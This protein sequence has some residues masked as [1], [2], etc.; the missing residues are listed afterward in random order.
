MLRII[1]L[2]SLFVTVAATA[3]L[4]IH[5]FVTPIS[6]PAAAT[7]HSIVS[8][9]LALLLVF[10]TN[11]SYDRWWEGRKLWGSMVNTCRNF[12]RA[13]S[14]HLA[15]D[16]DLLTRV[17]ELISAFPQATTAVLRGQDWAAAGLHE[18]DRKHILALAHRPTAVCQRITYHLKAARDRGLISDLVFLS[19]DA[20]CQTLVDVIGACERI[21]KTPLPFAY[22]VHLRRALV[23]YCATLPLALLSSFGWTTVPIVFGVSYV[24]LGIEEIGVEIEDPFE[25]DDND[26]PLEK[27][28]HSIETNVRAFRP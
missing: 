5:F 7:V 14:V 28:T 2:R 13:S 17:L 10:R 9:A 19:I 15:T 18:D 4:L 12:A 20:N 16:P 11:Q 23:L 27:I 3:L 1:T 25:G 24:L 21:H 22:V 26:L 8:P 6:S